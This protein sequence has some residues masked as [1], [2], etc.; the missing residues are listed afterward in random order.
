MRR[1]RVPSNEVGVHVPVEPVLAR[2]EGAAIVLEDVT[3]YSVGVVLRIRRVLQHPPEEVGGPRG[4]GHRH[5]MEQVM[6]GVA[7][8]DGRTASTV[9]PRDPS[10]PPALPGPA[11][12]ALRMTQGGGGDMQFSG[13]Y[14]LTP[15]PPDGPVTL[16]VAAPDVGISETTV[17]LDGSALQDAVTRV[18]I[19][20]PRSDLE[21]LPARPRPRPDV[22]PGGWFDRNS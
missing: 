10:G 6:L 4:P 2:A 20:W 3:V 16:V 8:S 1:F 22:P 14:L 13:Q 17:V 15:V 9:V 11:E 19:L 12:A 18:Q 21:D 5:P 7:F